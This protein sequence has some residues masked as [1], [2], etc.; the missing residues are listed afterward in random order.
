MFLLAEVAH[1]MATVLVAYGHNVKEEGLH[2]VVQSLVVQEE[3]GNETQI[4]AI[5]LLLLA[6]HFKHADFTVSVDLIPG[7]MSHGAFVLVS[8]Q[9]LLFLHILETKLTYVE[10]LRVSGEF[11]G[12][13]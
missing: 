2:I 6:I 13:G 5:D 11:F 7:R 1:H 8:L 10:F 12:I 9:R 3:L 4:L